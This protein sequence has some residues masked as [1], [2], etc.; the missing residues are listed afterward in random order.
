MK[1]QLSKIFWTVIILQILLVNGFS[2]A[3]AHPKSVEG[4]AGAA[5]PRLFLPIVNRVGQP[6]ALP[7]LEKFVE[8][9]KNGQSDV[10]RGAFVSNRLAAPVVQQPTDDP[11][12]VAAAADAVTEYRLADQYGT[13]GLLAD[14]TLTGRLFFNL[15]AGQQID[16]VYGDGAIKSYQI[17]RSESFKALNPTEADSNM[18][19]LASGATLTSGDVFNR[20]YR[21]SEHVT[22]HTHIARDGISNWGH[23]YVLALPVTMAA[24][25]PEKNVKLA[26]FHGPANN[27]TSEVIAENFDYIHLMRGEEAYRDELRKADYTA[28]ILQFIGFRTIFVTSSCSE[29]PG[30][31]TVAF[32]PGDYC[33]I[34]DN[35]P[36]WFMLD[37]NGDVL[38]DTWDG[39]SYAF[40]DPRN[41]GWREFFLSRI[42]TMQEDY[43]WDGL[44]IDNLDGGLGRFRE[45]GKMPAAFPDD[46]SMRTAY[47]DFINYLYTNYYQ[48]NARP[49]FAN[50]TFTSGVANWMNYLQ[51][52]DGAMMEGFGVDWD[53]GY[54]DAE[55]WETHLQIAEQAQAAGKEII[56]VAEGQQDNTAREEFSLASYLLINDGKA[57]FR[58]TYFTHY[59]DLWMYDNYGV[60]LG[61]PLG[62]R[63]Q[64]GDTWVR[65]FTGG[66]VRVN[67][68]THQASIVTYEY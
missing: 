26:W 30:Y 48:P 46:A 23:L 49:L 22:L 7:T 61:Q 66:Q 31:N 56:L 42:R 9:V 52:L 68:A 33:D 65:N 3:L 4:S 63:Y 59:N 15:S 43:D 47:G 21:G 11:D 62:T 38:M 54:L 53:N 1:T 32:K 51:Y 5:V 2:P 19:D 10:V 28:P 20:V 35:H 34:R 39:Q 40:M 18:V 12:Y 24:A 14:N 41:P 8:S 60:K 67:P 16:I 27:T 17:Y 57:S 55:E 25:Q 37:T 64:D 44:L 36:D 13:I 6:D 29:D 50:I 58:Y 45:I